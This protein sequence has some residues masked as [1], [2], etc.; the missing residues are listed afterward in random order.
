MKIPKLL[1]QM[2]VALDI[3]AADFTP[4]SIT[5][6]CNSG[7]VDETPAGD[8]KGGWTDQGKEN[9][10]S[11]FPQGKVEFNEIPF[12]IPQGD[13]TVVNRVLSFAFG[14]LNSF[15]NYAFLA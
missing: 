12:Q 7:F 2:L 8:G 10:L 14:F 4:L 15:R 1:L 11:G 5:E 6:Y 13:K 3:S 9:S